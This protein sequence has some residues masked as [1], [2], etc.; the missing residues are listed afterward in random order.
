M[1]MKGLKQKAKDLTMF[2]WLRWGAPLEALSRE[3]TQ[4]ALKISFG[5]EDGGQ[6]RGTLEAE[7]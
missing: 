4:S 5:Q 7:T 2:S 1:R 3:M 6:G